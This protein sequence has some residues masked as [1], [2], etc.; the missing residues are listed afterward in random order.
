CFQ[1]RRKMIRKSLQSLPH[2]KTNLP[3]GKARA[4]AMLQACAIDPTLRSEMLDITKFCALA[5][6]LGS[7]NIM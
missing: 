3:I 6:L 5:I 7:D 1:K 2:P 4:D